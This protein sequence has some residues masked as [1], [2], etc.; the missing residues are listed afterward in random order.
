M[1][2]DGRRISSPPC[3]FNL[4]VNIFGGIQIKKLIIIILLWLMYASPLVG[5][6]LAGHTS[7]C[8]WDCE[9]RRVNDSVGSRTGFHHP[10]RPRPGGPGVD[11]AE[12]R[13]K[14]CLRL[15]QQS[16]TEMIGQSTGRLD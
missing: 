13:I 10:A 16:I 11:E 15:S 14:W 7:R 4:T 3:Y 9:L 12:E 6:A 2:E 8:E 1:P 5:S